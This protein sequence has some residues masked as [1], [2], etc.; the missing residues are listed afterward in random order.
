M[1][2]TYDDI[3][4]VNK[5]VKYI[6]IHG[7]N[8]A[9]VAQRVQAFRNLYP[10]GF[11]TTDILRMD[12][13]IV[14]MKAEVGF[15]ENGQ[16]VVLSTGM[17]YERQDASKINQTSYIENCETSAI[18]RALGFIGLGSEN[19]IAS[20]EEVQQAI[21]TQEAIENGEIPVQPT[22]TVSMGDT[23]PPAELTPE[24]YLLREVNRLQQKFGE[25][26]NFMNCR[27]ALIDGGIVPN[28]R[29][30]E[31]NMKEAKALI[32]AIEETWEVPA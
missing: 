13:S 16:K 26:F 4:R 2:I 9:E 6:G 1:G 3:L 17:A 10:E 8:Y 29:S 5:A 14:Y 32:K 12:Q 22:A 25:S 20:A 18:G 21:D 7:K 15:Y 28:K 11:I 31:M 23:V 19:G 30:N 27:K 24:T